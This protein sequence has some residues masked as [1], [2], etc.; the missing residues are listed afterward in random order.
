[1][2]SQ[3]TFS[4]LNSLSRG[5]LQPPLPDVDRKVQACSAQPTRSGRGG[6]EPRCK[7]NVPGQTEPE[8]GQA[9]AGGCVRRGRGTVKRREES[10]TRRGP[11]G[12]QE[13]ESGEGGRG[14]RG[15]GLGNGWGTGADKGPQEPESWRQKMNGGQTP[16]RWPGEEEEAGVGLAQGPGRQR[17]RGPGRGRRRCGGRALTT[18][19]V[20]FTPGSAPGASRDASTSGVGESPVAGAG[21][22]GTEPRGRGAG[23]GSGRAS[24]PRR[25]RRGQRAPR[26]LPPQPGGK[27]G[28]V[29]ERR[30]RPQRARPPAGLLLLLLLGRGRAGQ[31]ALAAAPLRPPGL[32]PGPCHFLPSGEEGAGGLAGWGWRRGG[33]VEE[34]LPGQPDPSTPLPLLSSPPSLPRF[35]RFLPGPVAMATQLLGLPRPGWAPVPPPPPQPPRPSF[36]VLPLGWTDE[37]AE[38]LTSGGSPR[39]GVMGE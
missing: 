8:G 19:A 33:L 5:Y 1:M 27:G 21:G 32:P 3:T 9:D 30:S 35:P 22:A 16:W 26:L 14:S 12:A 15:R 6:R 18:A 4:E 28:G 36:S 39:E 31:R 23:G 20:T 13:S 11:R 7:G 17:T 24:A 29:A 37:G 34:V 10:Q 25:R 2:R 38:V